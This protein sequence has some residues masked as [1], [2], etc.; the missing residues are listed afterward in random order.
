MLLQHFH[1][2]FHAKHHESRSVRV[3]LG[4]AF[5]E[6]RGGKN[7]VLH[8]ISRLGVYGMGIFLASLVIKVAIVS[9][10]GHRY[11]GHV[12]DGLQFLRG[13]Q[14]VLCGLG[15]PYAPRQTFLV[16]AA[17]H[18]F[19]AYLYHIVVDAP[20]LEHPRH[21]VTSI[22]LGDSAEV[23]GHFGVFLLYALG[24]GKPYLVHSHV[25][26]QAIHLGGVR[27]LPGFIAKSPRVYQWRHGHIESTACIVAHLASQVIHLQETI[28][29]LGFLPAVDFAHDG[30]LVKHG[31]IR[32]HFPQF[33]LY[34]LP[35]VLLALIGDVVNRAE[36]KTG[37][38]LV[39]HATLLAD[40]ND[41]A[42]HQQRE[43]RQLPN[44]FLAI[45]CLIIQT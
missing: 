19:P 33:S 4:T 8:R 29:Q 3:G 28:A 40:D 44:E 45:H 9:A 7:I 34:L 39:G 26:S 38:L 37:D 43:Q 12:D 32:V 31:E 20:R 41:S 1:S 23:Q 27:H 14:G 36:S 21:P 11:V 2:A 6:H 15:H 16:D 42:Y 17:S 30:L 35:Q 24:L 25:S 22:S 18:D 13:S 5:R 10:C